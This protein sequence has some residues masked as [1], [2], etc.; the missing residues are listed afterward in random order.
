MYENLAAGVITYIPTPKFL[1]TVRGP[2]YG[3]VMGN[4]VEPFLAYHN[5][6]KK[7][8][9]EEYLWVEYHEFYNQKF[10]E[11]F[12][13]FD[14]WEDLKSILDKPKNIVDSRS[15]Q[16]PMIE[17]GKAESN[18]QFTKWKALVDSILLK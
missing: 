12:Y 14:S 9:E 11:W 2:S 5:I 4:N 6:T 16:S 13:H 17:F 1:K 3:M 15:L 10:K 7:R 8:W 18:E